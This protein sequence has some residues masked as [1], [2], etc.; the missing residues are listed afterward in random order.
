MEKGIDKGEL[1]LF[2]DVISA[3]D[4]IIR[5]QIGEQWLEHEFCKSVR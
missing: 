1:R 4:D 3:L 2:D 5:K